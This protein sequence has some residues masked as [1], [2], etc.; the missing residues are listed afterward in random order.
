MPAVI[1]REPP[2][3]GMGPDCSRIEIVSANGRR[4]AFCEIRHAGAE[5]VTTAVF[6]KPET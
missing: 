3:K 4:V 1:V 6:G 2:E 5:L